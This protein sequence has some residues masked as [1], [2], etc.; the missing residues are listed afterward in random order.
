MEEKKNYTMQIFFV[1]FPLGLVA[2]AWF[3]FHELK[4]LD[5]I[6]LTFAGVNLIYLIVSLIRNRKKR[7]GKE[8]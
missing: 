4:L 7:S 1:L 5:Y 6:L 2:I 8:S 3:G